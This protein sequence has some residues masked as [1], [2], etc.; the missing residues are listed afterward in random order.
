MELSTIWNITCVVLAFAF[1]IFVHELGHFVAAKALGFKVE[2]FAI[3]FGKKLFSL[4][5]GET[6]YSLRLV[7]LGGFNKLPEIDS[8]LA[9]I[10]WPLFW[11]RFVVLVAG[12]TFNILSAFVAIWIAI[13]FTGVP[14]GTSVVESV[15][16]GYAAD[17]ALQPKDNILSVNGVALDGEFNND[18]RNIITSNTSLDIALIRGGEEQT[19]HVNKD[20]DVPVGIMMERTVKTAP[21]FD[22]FGIAK[23]LSTALLTQIHDGFATLGKMGGGEIAKNVSGPVGIS[24][25][26]FAVKSQFGVTGLVFMFA[27]ISIQIGIFNL[28]PIPLLDGGR[29]TFDAVQLVTRNA[30]GERTVEAISYVGIAII[31]ALF[32]LGLGADLN[33]LLG[34]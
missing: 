28:L 26:M 7:P 24:T 9:R 18:I 22:S 12:A 11:R 23:N 21:F 33:R 20:K 32:L 17:G 34:G 5:R 29:I 10:T 4:K 25:E 2:E 3:G 30:F 13:A 1:I 6:E 14:T 15:V 31:G 8:M 19:V 27:V 16:S